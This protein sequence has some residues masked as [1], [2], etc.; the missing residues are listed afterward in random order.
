MTL[1]TLIL[2][3][4]SPNAAGPV[5]VSSVDSEAERKKQERAKRFASCTE[6]VPKQSA[7]KRLSSSKL[8]PVD[9]NDVLNNYCASS[10]YY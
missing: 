5:A 6:V 2:Q 3:L 9:D 8:S 7:I 4:C 1:A 10:M